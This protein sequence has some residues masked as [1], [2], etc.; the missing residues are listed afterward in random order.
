MEKYFNIKKILK[1]VKNEDNRFILV[2]FFFLFLQ[3]FV[4]LS[5]Y[6][7]DRYDVFF[8]FCNHTPLFFGFAF[9]LKKKDVIKGL[10]NVGFF[11]QFAW[12]LDFLGKMFFD[13]HI[14][15]M[16]NYVFENP[17]GLWIL[18]PIGI[19]IFAT[20]V[21]LYFTYKTK[22]SIY[23]AFY[24]LLYIMFLYAGTLT[25]TLV[26]RNVNW[27]YKIGGEINYSHDLYT[28]FWLILVFFLIVIPTQGFQYLLYKLYKKNVKK[29]K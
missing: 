11:G 18:V 23:S 9:L 27:I 25:Y 2:G 3:F 16:T 22:P 6:K 12:T 5:N 21:A 4:F 28:N 10:I 26:E 17:N 19:H 24:S 1:W 8:W 20:N 15:K 14:F 29:I 13:F 7:T